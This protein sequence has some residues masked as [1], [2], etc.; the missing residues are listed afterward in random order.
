M[1]L[2]GNRCWK[3]IRSR[4]C[5]AVPP[6]R[7]L[8]CVSVQGAIPGDDVA[9]LR[10]A[11]TYRPTWC[12][13]SLISIVR[14]LIVWTTARLWLRRCDS[15]HLERLPVYSSQRAVLLNL[16]KR[17]KLIYSVSRVLTVYCFWLLITWPAAF[18]ACP[19]LWLG[20][21]YV[22]RQHRN[23]S[24]PPPAVQ[25]SA[26]GRAWSASMAKIRLNFALSDPL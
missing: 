1:L 5:G 13:L 14:L 22:R 18:N 23:R 2:I 25:H 16:H 19:M 20:V 7:K 15:S 3:C 21:I 8:R 9:V 26:T 10:L 6:S 24:Y 4:Q 11:V 17:L 12:Q